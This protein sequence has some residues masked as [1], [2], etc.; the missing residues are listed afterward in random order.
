MLRLSNILALKQLLPWLLRYKPRF[1][2]HHLPYQ[3]SP[4]IHSSFFLGKSEKT[5]VM[6]FR[7]MVARRNKTLSHR[8]FRIIFKL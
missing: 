3:C 7:L 4:T 2:S 1:P 8:K 6:T 5:A